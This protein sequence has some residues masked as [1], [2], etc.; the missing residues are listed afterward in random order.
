MSTACLSA[1]APVTDF[2]DMLRDWLI[3]GKADPRAIDK[4]DELYELETNPIEIERLME[5]LADMKEC[6]DNLADALREAI[7]W[8]EES[9]CSSR[10]QQAKWALSRSSGVES[11]QV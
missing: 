5:E 8:L 6:R 2:L 3:A 7:T 10:I 9:D 11:D 1:H 4:I